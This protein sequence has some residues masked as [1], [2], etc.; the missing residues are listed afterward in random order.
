[1]IVP[2]TM[3]EALAPGDDPAW[4]LNEQGDDPLRESNR[5]SRFAIS[6]GFLGVRGA[7]SINRLPRAGVPP[8]TYV[9]GL[10]DTLETVGSVPGLIPVA[11]WLTLRILVNGKLLARDP[12][13]VLSRPLTL[14]MRRGVMLAD[15]HGPVDGATTGMRLRALRLVSLSERAL[16]LQ[17]RSTSSSKPASNRPIWGWWASGLNRTWVSGARNIQTGAWR[18]RL[19]RRCRS[20]AGMLSPPRLAP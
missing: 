4:T 18:W 15:W 3:G 13:H 9:A 12:T 19:L 20:T 11:D 16:G 2:R 14:Q 17:L 8:H 1:M 5:E 7:R 10:F 6:N